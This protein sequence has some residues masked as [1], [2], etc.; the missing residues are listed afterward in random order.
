[1]VVIKLDE[2]IR[3]KKRFKRRTDTNVGEEET[4]LENG[5]D[6]LFAPNEAEW[7]CPLTAKTPEIRCLSGFRS[8]FLYFGD[9]M[10]T[11]GG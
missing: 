6:K 3:F 7:L 9:K 4:H 5:E 1:M 2:K 10:A 8:L 11:T